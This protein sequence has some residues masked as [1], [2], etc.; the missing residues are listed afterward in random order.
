MLASRFNTAKIYE[1]ALSSRGETRQPNVSYSSLPK[2]CCLTR[3]SRGG[4]GNE[5]L[6]L[7]RIA[8]A[9]SRLRVNCFSKAGDGVKIEYTSRKENGLWRLFVAPS[10]PIL[11]VYHCQSVKEIRRS[12]VGENLKAVIPLSTKALDKHAFRGMVLSSR[13]NRNVTSVGCRYPRRNQAAHSHRISIAKALENM[14]A[15]GDARSLG[16]GNLR[17]PETADK[18]FLTTGQSLNTQYSANLRHRRWADQ[19]ERELVFNTSLL[20]MT[21]TTFFK[22]QQYRNWFSQSSY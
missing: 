5:T 19:A 4:G 14:H 12:K 10:N 8:D 17:V 11:A 1:L 3:Q 15:T 16:S 20:S 2:R 9:Q 22:S 18:L 13:S 6:S 21:Y 7:H